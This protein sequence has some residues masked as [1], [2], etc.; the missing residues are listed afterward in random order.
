MSS[1]FKLPPE[2][3]QRIYEEI[4]DVGKVFPYTL[5][6]SY[7]EYDCDDHDDLT[8]RGFAGHE[9]TKVA[10]LIVCKGIHAEAEPVLYRQNRF[11]LPASDLTARFF[12]RSLHNDTCGDWVKSVEIGLI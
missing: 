9:A 2:I 10:L 11:V 6:E 12:N 8:A 7:N 5:G 3:R 4:L 1:L